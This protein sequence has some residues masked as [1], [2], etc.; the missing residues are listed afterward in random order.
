MV[1]RAGG[2]SFAFLFCFSGTLKS[3]GCTFS[4]PNVYEY[5]SPIMYQIAISARALVITNVAN[6]WAHELDQ[7][8]QNNDSRRSSWFRYRMRQ[9][10]VFF[11]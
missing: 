3:D 1:G 8:H 5:V 9:I 2:V 11:P 6:A 4:V 7:Y 10:M